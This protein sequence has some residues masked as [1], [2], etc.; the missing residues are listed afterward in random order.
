MS[1]DGEN[2]Y[3][4][5]SN[6]ILMVNIYIYG[7]T[8]RSIENLQLDGGCPVFDF[9]NTIN[10][11]NSAQ[12]YDY[13]GDYEHILL[14]NAKAGLLTPERV[15]LLSQ[16]ASQHQPERELAFWKAKRIREILYQL[17]S[18]IGKRQVVDAHILN[19]FNEVLS[20]CLGKLKLDI[21]ASGPNVNFTGKNISLDEPVCIIMKSAYDILTNEDFARLK[22]CPSCGWLFIDRTKNARRRWCDMKVCGSRDKAKRYYHRKNEE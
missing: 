8:E 7:M 10:N 21:T 19:V 4:L 3:L 9:T 11:R 16:Y 14:W 17:F 20:E 1:F 15:R 6:D 22:E 13:L 2:K 12:S 18:S 5:P